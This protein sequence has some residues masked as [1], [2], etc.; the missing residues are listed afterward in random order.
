MPN[1]IPPTA[2]GW[3]YVAGIVLAAVA[4]IAAAVLAVLGLDEWQPVLTVAASAVG[5]ALGTLARSNLADD[6]TTAA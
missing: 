3:L 4:S 1:P 5:I 2:R 6:D